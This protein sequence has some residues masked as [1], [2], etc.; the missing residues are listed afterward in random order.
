[1]GLDSS[2]LCCSFSCINPVVLSMRRVLG[3]RDAK[4]SPAHGTAAGLWPSSAHCLLLV[5]HY[6]APVVQAG[7]GQRSPRD[8]AAGGAATT[9]AF[10]SNCVFSPRRTWACRL[11][12][13]N[14]WFPSLSRTLWVLTPWCCI[15]IGVPSLLPSLSQPSSLQR[16]SRWFVLKGPRSDTNRGSETEVTV[17][18]GQQASVVTSLPQDHASADN[19]RFEGDWSVGDWSATCSESTCGNFR[20]RR[21]LLG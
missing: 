4:F 18:S 3:H 19:K 16:E 14:K 17:T 9:L 21:Q 20:R 12:T 11:S 5:L 13:A 15:E 1:M 8:A 7:E 10:V 6:L 2:F